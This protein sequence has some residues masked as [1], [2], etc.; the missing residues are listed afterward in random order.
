MLIIP[1]CH[2]PPRPAVLRVHHSDGSQR[3][4]LTAIQRPAVLRVHHGAQRHIRRGGA[5]DLPGAA[6]ATVS[7]SQSHPLPTDLA[8]QDQVALHGQ[9]GGGGR[10]RLRAVLHEGRWYTLPA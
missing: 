7:L 1:T 8:G 2:L 4:S 9:H 3:L 6:T 5:G 10:E